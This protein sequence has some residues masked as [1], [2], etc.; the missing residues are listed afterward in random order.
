MHESLK[1]QRVMITAG[2]QGIGKAIALAFLDAGAQVAVCDINQDSL[3]AVRADHPNLVTCVADVSDPTQV[4][5]FFE[6]AQAQLGGLDVLVNNAGSAGPTAPIEDI[7]PKDWSRTLAI[8]LDAGFLCLRH[9]V[10]IMKAA[11]RGVI[12][13]LSSTAGQFGFPLRAP[14]CAAKW[15]VIGLT[16]TL[17]MELGP[18]GIRANAICPGSVDGPRMDQVIASNAAARGLTP[19]E[20]RRT[21]ENQVSLKTFVTTEDIARTALFLCTD[22]ARYISGQA[23]AVDG[24]TESLVS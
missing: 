17:A 19:D 10:P 21:F 24:H 20:V 4:A 5:R 3:M 6:T 23:I 14:Y 7:D 11:G 9:A 16:K 13:N 15:A 18:F 8:N 12:I 22:L 1:G 2:A